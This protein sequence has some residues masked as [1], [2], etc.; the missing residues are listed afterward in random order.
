MSLVNNV[1]RELDG[2]REVPSQG[3]S[4]PEFVNSNEIEK[5][6]PYQVIFLLIIFSLVVI[7]S[8]QLI[9]EKPLSTLLFNNI[10]PSSELSA[11]NYEVTQTNNNPVNIDIIEVESL[12]I[13]SI[14]GVQHKHKLSSEYVQENPSRIEKI[15]KVEKVI[16]QKITA[17][18][19]T[20]AIRKV[21]VAGSI[22]YQR[23]VKAYKQKRYTVALA[24][25]NAAIK[26][27]QSEKYQVLKAT[28]L[29]KQR[30]SS[31]F[32]QFVQQGSANTSLNW[33]QLVAPGL[34]LLSYYELSN[35]YYLQL[36]KQQ[37]ENIK[38]PLAMALNYTR[39]DK[40]DETHEIY[41]SLLKTSLLSM[42]QK[43]WILSQ[44]KSMRKSSGNNEGHRNGS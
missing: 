41:Q 7:L 27:S 37:P 26:E 8:V 21:A 36:I 39:L 35:K 40:A 29:L 9:Y 30:D 34:Q 3:L 33:F 19:V 22:D 10:S 17:K 4:F 5:K 6:R 1:L 42:K 43:K 31:G 38:W 2:R 18:K 12:T 20:V 32:V 11:A 28:I 44:I 24:R 16:P 13:P 14:D 15:K 23:A 25:V